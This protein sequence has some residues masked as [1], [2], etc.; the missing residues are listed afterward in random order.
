MKPLI[1]MSHASFLALVREKVFVPIIF[2]GVIIALFASAAADLGLVGYVR[3]LYHIGYFGFQMMGCLVAILWGTRVFHDVIRDGS[4]QIQLVGPISRTHWLM[5]R[6]FGLFFCLVIIAGLFIFI[7]QGF[8]FL[9]GF[10]WL[11]VYRFET[12]ALL[13]ITWFVMATFA[14][15]FT[16]FLGISVA[17]ISCFVVLFLGLISGA[18]SGSMGAEESGITGYV[19]NALDLFL[20]FEHFNLVERKPENIS[21]GFDVLWWPTAYGFAFIT[22][23]SYFAC[24]IFESRDIL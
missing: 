1:V 14:M 18:L 10:G 8:L 20:N 13:S 6:L 24:K 21:F 2:A 16:T 11:E 12:F 9:N 5:G 15:F 3:V 22:V 17:T 19:V 23:L 7:W 4:G